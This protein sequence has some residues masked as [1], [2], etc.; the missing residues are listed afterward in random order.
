M[1]KQKSGTIINISSSCATH[2]WPSFSV[3][4]AAKAGLSHFSTSLYTELRPYGVRVSCIEPSWGDT[5]FC[6][7]A[8]IPAMSRDL[9]NKCISPEDIGDLVV[10]TCS[11]PAHLVIDKVSM[12]PLV[13]EVIPL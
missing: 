9:L 11:L 4:S 1:K 8:K 7:A 6:Q 3:Y 5:G 12:W 13:Q 10:F 2:A